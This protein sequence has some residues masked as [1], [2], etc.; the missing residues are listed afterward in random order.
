LNSSGL[1]MVA[2]GVWC[3]LQREV[4]SSGDAAK[5]YSGWATQSKGVYSRTSTEM[6]LVGRQAGKASTAKKVCIPTD[7][8]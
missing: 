2:D 6:Q 7:T 4:G 1:L 8:F 3:A 5:D